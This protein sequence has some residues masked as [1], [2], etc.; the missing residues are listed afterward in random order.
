VKPW[1]PVLVS[2]YG[3][4]TTTLAIFWHVVRQDS[5]VYGWV[6]HD[7]DLAIAGVTYRAAAGLR[8][9]AA[10]TTVDMQ[11]G[12]LDVSAFLDVSTEADLEAGVWDE[13]QVTIFEARWDVLPTALDATQCNILLYGK[14][15]KIDRQTGVF[16]GQLH[17]L[18]EQLDTQI[19]RVYSATCPWRLGDSRCQVDLGPWTRT[20]TVTGIGADG[21]YQFSD[22]AQ[23]EDDGWFNEGVVTFTSGGHTGRSVD[24]RQWAGHTFHLHRPLPFPVEIGASYS[25]IRGDDKRLVT[26]AGVFENQQRFGG[27]PTLP[28]VDAVM[29]NPLT[30]PL[31]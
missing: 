20:G 31:T 9:S 27:F 23:G 5:Q 17:G 10:Q 6:E 14:L 3:R 7:R 25:A 8:A 19:G 24:V 26:C 16:Q 4:S 15:G 29:R 22:S 18:L 12:T 30:R 28:G 2:H 21:R 11:P 1:S 13:A